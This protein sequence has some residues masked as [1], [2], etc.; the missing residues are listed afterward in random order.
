MIVVLLWIAGVGIRILWKNSEFWSLV[1][2]STNFVKLD[3]HYADKPVWKL[4]AFYGCPERSRRRVSWDMLKSICA[5]VTS[6]WVYM[7]DFNDL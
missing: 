3:V 4:T 2:F 6:P 7:G 5:I 1:N